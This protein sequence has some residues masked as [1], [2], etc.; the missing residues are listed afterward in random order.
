MHTLKLVCVYSVGLFCFNHKLKV[1][2]I[3]F[4]ILSILGF[5]YFSSRNSMQVCILFLSYVSLTPFVWDLCTCLF[6]YALVFP[7]HFLVCAGKA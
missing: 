1:T 3:C 6:V 5:G 7:T 2:I 4:R